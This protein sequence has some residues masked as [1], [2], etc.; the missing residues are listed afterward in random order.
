MHIRFG[1]MLLAS[2]AIL[3]AP[4]ASAQSSS[5]EARLQ[6]LEAMVQQLR[7]ELAAERAQTDSDLI[8]LE[9]RAAEIVA[10]EAAKTGGGFQ[11]GNTTFKLGGFVDLDTHVSNFT[12][13][14]L[15]SG[16]GGRDF[17]IPFTT[18][19]QS[20]DA[21]G[22][23]VDNE[24]STVT[25]LTAQATRFAV[26][27]QR[28]VGGKKATAY[29]ETDFLLANVEGNERISNS[30]SPR[31]R[32]A[33]IDY[34][35]WRIGQ[36]WSTFQNTSAIPESASFF[37]LAE[38]QIFIRQPQIRYTKG[39][40][41]F[42]L[43]NANA[44][45]IPSGGTSPLGV[46]ADASLVPDAVARYNLKGSFGNVSLS[47]IGRQLWFDPTAPDGTPLGSE[48]RGDF[49]WG[50]S[51][52]GRVKLG[53]G[54]VRFSVS[55]GEGLGR[56]IGLNLVAGAAVDP[57]TGDVEAI[58]SIGGH[59]AYRHPLSDNTRFSLGVSQLSVDNPDF[60]AG[61]ISDRAR[62]AFAAL[63][64]DPIPKVTFGIEGLLG[65]RRT[66]D[67][68]DGALRRATFSAKYGF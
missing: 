27:A 9:K 53:A 12:Q 51:A 40:F 36:E 14:A 56:Y 63:F 55:G 11:V 39:N 17:H 16:S 31:L 68:A 49:G 42:A 59:I 47:A 44:T 18:P 29:I 34:N 62:S 22:T 61:S 13:G 7:S 57:L 5:T 1:A 38:G 6:A 3:T 21:N 8:L 50:L 10:P 60:V 52:A 24:G 64:W 48:S 37:T 58:Q 46:V 54:D 67:G 41:Q 4:M 66:E 30:F 35:G 32:R 25:D 15:G 20:L 43:E 19:V 26:T 23:P 45:V 28:E 33:Y 65:D 2:T